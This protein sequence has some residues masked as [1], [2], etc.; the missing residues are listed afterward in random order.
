MDTLVMNNVR[1]ELMKVNPEFR[2]LVQQ[3]QN[4][5]KRLNELSSLHYPSDEEQIEE[6]LLKKKKLAV[7]DEI[8]Q[9]ILEY[10]KKNNISH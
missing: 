2:D 8:Y 9:M 10:S 7:K 6:S 5:E 4:Y 1:D 3:H